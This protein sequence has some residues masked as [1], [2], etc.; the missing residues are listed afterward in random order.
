MIE[1]DETGKTKP[2]L[3]PDPARVE[4]LTNMK[5]P[6]TKSEVRSLLGL[7]TQLSKFCPDYAQNV[8]A[9]RQ[10]T[11]KDVQFLWTD[12]HQREFDKVIA[13]FGNLEY[14]R[15]YD[16]TNQLF[17][18][19]DASYL[20]LG[21]ILFQ[22]DKDNSWSIVMVGSTCL[23]NAQIRWHPTELELLAVYYCL[24]K[25]HYFTANTRLPI[26]VYSDCSGLRNFELLDI[27]S[28]SN[29]RMINLRDKLQCYNYTISHIAGK[30]NNIADSLSRT[31]SWF[32]KD[33]AFK[34]SSNI[35]VEEGVIKFLAT[36][37][38]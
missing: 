38:S 20:G 26:V 19:T 3:G 18:L 36:I 28:M 29:K 2:K 27:T 21:F 9:L 23:K 33:E 17:C 7:L 15:P 16:P 24:S 22:K 8:P 37:D 14:L 32:T 5:R 30:R 31:P 13:N 4:K 6:T 34:S 35:N 10:L 1:T 11:H 12:I 25:C